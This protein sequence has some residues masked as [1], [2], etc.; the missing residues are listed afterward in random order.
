MNILLALKICIGLA[1]LAVL[2]STGATLVLSSRISREEEKKIEN[3]SV[4]EGG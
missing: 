1:T 4:R 3:V 2:I